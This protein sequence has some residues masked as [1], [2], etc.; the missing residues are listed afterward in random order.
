LGGGSA[1]SRLDEDAPTVEA[2]MAATAAELGGTYE[3]LERCVSFINMGIM[4]IP[5]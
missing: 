2:M 1:P 3:I 5:F 4:I